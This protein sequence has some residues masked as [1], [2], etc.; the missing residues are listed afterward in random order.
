M[1]DKLPLISSTIN[2]VGILLGIIGAYL[3]WKNGLPPAD[4]EPATL[5]LMADN[6]EE[7]AKKRAEYA[8]KSRC[9]MMLLILSFAL[10]FASA[11]LS[12]ITLK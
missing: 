10:Q 12:I 8:G 9:G 2:A 11:I 1:R 7:R 3:I 5:T 6:P 4:I